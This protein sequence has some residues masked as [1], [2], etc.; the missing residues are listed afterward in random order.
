MTV[1]EREVPEFLCAELKLSQDQNELISVICLTGHKGK[2]I[3]FRASTSSEGSDE[4]PIRLF[5][6]ELATLF[7]A[8]S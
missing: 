6:N 1:G 5:L 2:F 3:K 7:W 8:N 4:L